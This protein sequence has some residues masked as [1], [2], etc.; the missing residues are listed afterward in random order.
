MATVAVLNGGSNEPTTLRLA[1]DAGAVAVPQANGC[2]DVGLAFTPAAN[3]LPI[4]WHDMAAG[5]KIEVATVWAQFPA[6][7]IA[8]LNRRDTRLALDRCRYGSPMHEVDALIDV[9][10][11]GLTRTYQGLWERVADSDVTTPSVEDAS[12]A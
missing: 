5:S 3:A 10:E 4:R 8:A 1:S 2:I 12:D 6:L 7:E 9:D 11:L